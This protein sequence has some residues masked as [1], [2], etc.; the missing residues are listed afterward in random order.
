M[1]Y[2]VLDRNLQGSYACRE[3]A[4]GEQHLM[5]EYPVHSSFQTSRSLTALYVVLSWLVYL[6]HDA[7]DRN[8]RRHREPGQHRVL[9]LQAKETRVFQV[10]FRGLVCVQSNTIIGGR[11][12]ESRGTLTCR[13]KACDHE[14]F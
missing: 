3:N 14:C 2:F 5:L 6:E 4:D 1:Q 7:E 13:D 8:S 12:L 11:S 9:V 10:R